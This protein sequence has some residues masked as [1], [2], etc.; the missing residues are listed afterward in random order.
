VNLDTA[1]LTGVMV[2]ALSDRADR[3]RGLESSADDFLTKP[4][5]DGALFARIR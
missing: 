3:V 1:H 4:V 2:T 5:A